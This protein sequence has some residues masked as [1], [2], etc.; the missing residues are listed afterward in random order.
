MVRNFLVTL[1]LLFVANLTFAQTTLAGKV[2]DGGTGEELISAS[3]VITKN[4]TFIQG[5]VTDFDG[6]FSI[7][8]DPG[9]YDV[10]IS[11]TGYQT[12][13][14]TDII[15]TEGNATKV[16]MQLNS[17]VVTKE[18]VIVGYKVPLIKQ[19]E[20]SQ[21]RTVTSEQI[22]NLPT[23]N[24]NAVAAATAGAS[25]ADE[26]GAVTIKGSRSNACLLYTSP[27]PR[28]ATLSRMPSSA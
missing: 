1:S 24:I 22:K 23:R 20:T 4:G 27:S 7:R 5:D 11:Y 13:R 2:T 9:T 10:E 12:Q 14:I 25:T 18:V 21:G 6:N 8:V 26:G 17:G 16:D 19:D 3:I 28:D 15:A